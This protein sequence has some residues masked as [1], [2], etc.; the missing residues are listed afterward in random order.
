MGWQ[1]TVDFEKD[2]ASL[3]KNMTTRPVEVFARPY[4]GHILFLLSGQEKDLIN[5]VARQIEPLHAATGAV[6]AFV[7]VSAVTRL[8]VEVSGGMKRDREKKEFAV[9]LATLEEGRGGQ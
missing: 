3:L 2:G 4:L 1:L 9:D 5:S 6:I 7:I 8:P